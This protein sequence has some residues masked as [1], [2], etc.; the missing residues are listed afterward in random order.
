LTSKRRGKPSNN[1]LDPETKHEAIDLL[2][3]RY[4]DF[5]PTLAHEKLSEVHEPKLSVESVRQIMIAE[6]L[7]K[8]RKG[9]RQA[10]QETYLHD[11][12]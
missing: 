11:Q 4:Y 8:P 12:N 10:I 5:R 9:K 1:N 2:H 6:S 3:S 7:W